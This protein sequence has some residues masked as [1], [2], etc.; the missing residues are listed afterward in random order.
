MAQ[1]SSQASSSTATRHRARTPE[2]TSTDDLF[3]PG[4]R[5][6]TVPNIPP[7][8]GI[9]MRVMPHVSRCPI[10]EPPRSIQLE[11]DTV[12]L[13]ASHLE[14]VEIVGGCPIIRT[15]SSGLELVNFRENVGQGAL[16]DA[17]PKPAGW[18]ERILLIC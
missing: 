3:I 13:V 15:P 17:R 4:V 9:D 16:G 5:N 7:T 14:T 6:I 1:K 12:A 11:E 18:S 10:F 8:I 2:I